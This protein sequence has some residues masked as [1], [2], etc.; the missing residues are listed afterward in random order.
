M[1]NPLFYPVLPILYFLGAIPCFALGPLAGYSYLGF[2]IVLAYVGH[3]YWAKHQHYFSDEMLSSERIKKAR[4]ELYGRWDTG[5]APR[6]NPDAT[7]SRT[8]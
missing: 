5:A 1:L 2:T 8:A 4:Q 6:K 3:R 7:P